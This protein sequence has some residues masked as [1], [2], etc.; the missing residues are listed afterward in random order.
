MD[1]SLRLEI[2]AD[3][4]SSLNSIGASGGTNIEDGLDK[5]FETFTGSGRKV[6]ILLTDGKSNEN[7]ALQMIQKAKEKGIT[8]YTI[9]LGTQVSED[10]L[11]RLASETGG[12]YYH[13]KENIQIGEAYQSILNQIGCGVPVLS[14]SNPAQAFLSPA[15]ETT[16]EDLYMSTNISRG[17]GEISRVVVRFNSYDGD[18]DY[19]LVYRGQNYFALKRGVNEI[20][21]F[22]LLQDSQLLAYNDDGSLVGYRRVPILKQ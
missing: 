7:Q 5:A 6:A 19:E 9:G 22:D 3:V 4:S 11:Q 1:T 14:C 16:N 2:L 13:I 15:I 12:Q 18:I 8:I 10:L 20:T 21:N 17:C